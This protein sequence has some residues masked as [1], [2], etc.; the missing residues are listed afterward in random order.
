MECLSFIFSAIIGFI[1]K[2]EEVGNAQ[3]ENFLLRQFQA[4]TV[5]GYHH[6]LY[7]KVEKFEFSNPKGDT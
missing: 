2:S 5:F 1:V 3:T 6:P 7:P 4:R